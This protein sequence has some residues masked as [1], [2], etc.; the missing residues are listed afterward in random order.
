MFELG[1]KYFVMT[2]TYFIVGELVDQDDKF[3][4]FKTVSM[5]ADTGRFTDFLRDGKKEGMEIE[6]FAN[7]VIIAKGAIVNAT[8]WKHDLFTDPV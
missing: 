7:D 4:K 2:V 1:K 5:V 6:L 8:E 3:L